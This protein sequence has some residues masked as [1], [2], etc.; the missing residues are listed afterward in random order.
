MKKKNKQVT[1]VAVKPT[2]ADRGFNIVV[3]IFMVF[4]L[5]VIVLPLWSTLTLSF[6]PVTF[7]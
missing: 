3:D 5:I 4:I 6:R 7:I 2:A 1:S